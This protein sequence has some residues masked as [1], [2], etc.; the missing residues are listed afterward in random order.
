MDGYALR[1]ADAQTQR[2]LPISAEIRAG[3]KPQPLAAGSAA[4][5]FTG[6]PLPTG[7]DTVVMQEDT[8]RADSTVTFTSLPAR[9]GA[10]V[11]VRG[12][13]LRAG[14]ALFAPGTLLGP[15]E[16]GLLA[17]Q[18]HGSVEVYRKPRVGVLATG[19]E[20]R[21]LSAPAAPFTIVD[22][23]TYSLIAALER[24][25][26][27][28]VALGIASDDRATIQAR[29]EEGLSYDALITVGGVS[30]GEYDLVSDALQAASVKI[31]LHKVAIKPGKPLLFGMRGTTPVIG[32][33]GNPVSAL[34][35]FEIFVRP[36]LLRMQ[37]LDRV[38]PEPVPVQL[39]TAY[40]RKPGRTEFVR[41]H[42][43]YENSTWVAHIFHQQ[44]SAALS[45]L[46]AG[47]ALV[48]VPAERGRVEAGETLKAILPAL[49]RRAEPAFAD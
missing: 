8:S 17:S 42:L 38:Y 4:R 23:N 11:R 1:W 3:D 5:I 44:G 14:Q 48:I 13:E 37:G 12:S 30:V 34:V 32:L 47:S 43:R 9:P 21:A 40:D 19:N 33:P 25:G 15:G 45:S 10:H 26:C 27:E 20:L 28:P 6:A 46:T 7:A 35:V 22:S 16:L 41:A 18:G 39:A 2:T 49:P 24:A 36:G 31:E 29:V